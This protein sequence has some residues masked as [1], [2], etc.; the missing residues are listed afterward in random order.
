MTNLPCV[1]TVE[2]IAQWKKNNQQ[3]TRQCAEKINPHG[4]KTTIN[5]FGHH[6][7]SSRMKK[8]KR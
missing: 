7:M 3:L 1:V 6:L 5:E 8:T 2:D 4:T